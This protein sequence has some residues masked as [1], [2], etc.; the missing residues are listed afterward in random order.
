LL[1]FCDSLAYA[2][3]KRLSGWK[4]ELLRAHDL[5]AG[6]FARSET[7]ARSLAYLQGL[8]SNCERKNGWQLA[9]WMGEVSPYA[10]QHLLD[11]ARWDAD[12]VRD[13]T[14]SY[15]LE[16]L[17]SADAVLI[18]DETGFLKKGRHS[19][20]VKRQYSG[21]AGRIEN[22][23]VGVFLCYGSDKGAALVDRE[24]YIPQEWA[25]DRERRSEAGI[26]ESLEFATKPEL[27][28][29]MIGRALDSGAAAAWVAADEVY[30]HDSKLR[31][32]LEGRQMAYVL[33]VASDQRLWQADFMQH[34]VDAMAR[35]LPASRWKRLSAGFG[36][37]GERLYD[38]AL[39]PLSKQD[40]WARAL[41]VRRSIEE[42]PE[43]AY[44]LCYAPNGQD[45]IE[46]LVR[47]AGQ[48]WKIEQAFETA[49]GECGLDHYEV[50]HWQ[51]W[52]RHITLSMLAHAV[53]SVLRA[54]GEKNSRRASAAQRTGTT[55]LAHRNAVAR[56]ARH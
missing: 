51:G 5:I 21:T 27:A 10:V 3:E 55:P 33:A 24:L 23:Q 32:F 1:W 28:R 40:G 31:R 53:L 56:M 49:K 17:S 22:S 36:S 52:Y 50:R 30:G 15:A 2:M 13:Q 37:K 38:W 48:R 35:N 20:G 34:R 29:R 42:K 12:Q 4:R 43:F 44:Y 45:T 39:M 19:T 7:R 26:P 11:R 25:E 9:E 8:L 41:L 6:L 16:E 14:R 54:R 18:V 47:V 46:T